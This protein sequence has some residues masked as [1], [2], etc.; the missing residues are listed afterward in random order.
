MTYPSKRSAFFAAGGTLPLDSPSY[1]RRDSDETLYSYLSEGEFCYVLDSRQVGKSSLV[2][3]VKD[4]LKRDGVQVAQLDLQ[5]IGQNVTAEQWYGSLLTQLGDE[6]GLGDEVYDFFQEVKRQERLGPLQRWIDS[7]TDVVLPRCPGRIVIFVDEIDQVRTLHSR[8]STDE[9]FTGIRELFNRRSSNPD[10][11]RITFCLIGCATPSELI[12]DVRTTPFNIGHRVELT[13]FSPAEA[14]CLAEGLGQDRHVAS[15]L[16]ERILYWTGGHPFLTQ[17]FCQEVANREEIKTVADID[18]LVEELY[19]SRRGQV[20][21]HNLRF[22]RDKVH[23]ASDLAGLL[24]LYAR[25]RRDKP[26]AD[27]PTNPLI[28]IMRLSGI[29]RIAQG[30]HYVRNRIY[31]R[32]FDRQWIRQNMPG[33]ERRRQRSAYIRGAL[34]ATAVLAIILGVFAQQYREKAKALNAAQEEKAIAEGAKRES[35]RK[36]EQLQREEIALRRA[37]F[38]A[39]VTAQRE[40][41][42]RLQELDNFLNLMDQLIRFSSP[43]QQASW[44]P[45]KGHILLQQGKLAEAERVLSSA[46]V[47]APDNRIARS[48]RGYSYLL[49]RQPKQALG[50]FNY[51]RDHLDANSSLNFLDL[52]LVQAQLGEYQAARASLHKAI[53]KWLVGQF[54]VIGDPL[55]APE[56]T[57]ATERT[58][59][60]LDADSLKAALQF[61]AANLEAYAG[62]LDGYKLELDKA[63]KELA[64]L[65]LPD[66]LREDVYLIA[67]NWA[68]FQLRTRPGDYGARASQAMLWRQAKREDRA[69]CDFQQFLTSW[70][71]KPDPRYSSLASWVN[72]VAKPQASSSK[73]NDLYPCQGKTP[74]AFE[75]ELKA[76]EEQAS[77]RVEQA[78]RDFNAAEQTWSSVRVLLE[79]ARLFLEAEVRAWGRSAELRSSQQAKAPGKGSDE[80]KKKQALAAKF[81]SEAKAQFTK[82]QHLCNRIIEKAPQTANAYNYRALAK[83]WLDPDHSPTQ[84]ILADAHKALKLE[85]SNTLALQ[86]IDKMVPQRSPAQERYLEQEKPYLER[87][88]L[89]WGGDANTYLHLASLAETEKRHLEAV[90]LSNTAVAMD[91]LNLEAY[92]V[93][94]QAEEGLHLDETLIKGDLVE[95]YRHAADA[96]T[97]RLLDATQ[98]EQGWRNAADV[99]IGDKTG[100]VTRCD[101]LL[102]ACISTQPAVAPHREVIYAVILSVT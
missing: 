57:E 92:Q 74:D 62:N 71:T 73:F 27:D 55:V 93:R 90:Q 44:L 99:R 91:T 31:Y 58:T 15:A 21:D 9:F 68:W 49:L 72:S 3:R 78:E 47:L 79:E 24:D 2:V 89:L 23:E 8:F 66:E 50:D 75:L 12:K 5:S 65:D 36:Q 7:L 76:L 38:G 101:S 28:T 43:E 100:D 59:V 81:E 26:V 87:Y 19:F 1:V 34:A 51:V 6:L 85:P 17:R 40:R 94:K 86:L 80:D 84:E 53:D 82:L 4:R 88:Q 52:A 46:L 20:E 97:A 29:T 30:Y 13:D 39:R 10:L 25:V 18:R 70:Q 61:M 83:Y 102:S 54:D 98:A 33:A 22:V 48:S 77:G 37:E 35:D 16:L 60:Y 96:L 42:Q 14:A 56:I 32:V 64:S 11:R 95:G 45:I 67:V 69:A 63:R 41:R